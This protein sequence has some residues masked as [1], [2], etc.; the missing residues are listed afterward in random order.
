MRFRGSHVV[1]T[2]FRFLASGGGHSHQRGPISLRAG[3]SPTA[4]GVSDFPPV[5]IAGPAL[6]FGSTR[7]GAW[8]AR[9]R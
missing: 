5:G 7:S 4:V 6:A 1:D 3:V 8:W 2:G 9:R